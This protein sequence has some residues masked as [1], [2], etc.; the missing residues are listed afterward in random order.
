MAERGTIPGDIR[1]T[2]SKM[3]PDLSTEEQG[4]WV[5]E[6]RTALLNGKYWGPLAHLRR[7]LIKCQEAG[8]RPSPLE[9]ARWYIEDEQRERRE[10]LAIAHRQEEAERVKAEEALTPLTE[11]EVRRREWNS[12]WLQ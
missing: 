11:E 2:I 5:T 8:K 3:V 1:Y 9:W 7:Y 12:Q 10:V 6:V 4:Q